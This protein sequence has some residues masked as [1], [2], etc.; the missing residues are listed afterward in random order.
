MYFHVGL[1]ARQDAIAKLFYKIKERVQKNVVWC[2]DP[3]LTWYG[4]DHPRYQKT[5]PRVL[6]E[7]I[8][9][10]SIWNIRF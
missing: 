6:R 10:Q 9:P 7:L 1:V 3:S 8:D 4:V 5:E 2:A